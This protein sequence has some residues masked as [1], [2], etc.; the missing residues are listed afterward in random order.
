MIQRKL[1]QDHRPGDFLICKD[2]FYFVIHNDV[3]SG[4]IS[5][6]DKDHFNNEIKIGINYKSYDYHEESEDH[7]IYV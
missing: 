3:I 1:M 4:C 7:V 5:Y 6:Y 2:Y